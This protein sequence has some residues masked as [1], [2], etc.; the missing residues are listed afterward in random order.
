MT[1]THTARAWSIKGLGG[2]EESVA[3]HFVAVSTNAAEVSKF[4]IDTD[5]PE[6]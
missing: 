3:R 4:G 1:N 2:D 5:R 6:T